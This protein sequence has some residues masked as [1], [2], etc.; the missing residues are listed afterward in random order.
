MISNILLGDYMEENINMTEHKAYTNKFDKEIFIQF[1]NIAI[2][3]NR[4]LSWFLNLKIEEMNDK[5]DLKK[6]EENDNYNR[7]SVYLTD[8]NHRFAKNM[9]YIHDITMRD[10]IQSVMEATIRE[11]NKEQPQNYQYEHLYDII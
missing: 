3:N 1:K 7:K 2:E 5:I 10:Y 6:Y 9:F 4:S 11:E 8:K